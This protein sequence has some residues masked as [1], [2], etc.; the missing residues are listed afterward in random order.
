MINHIMV[1]GFIFTI[2]MFL[3][4]YLCLY[5]RYTYVTGLSVVHEKKRIEGKGNFEFLLQEDE[6]EVMLNM[7]VDIN[8]ACS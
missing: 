1:I 3:F 2:M 7:Y 5:C 6:I 4:F 8:L